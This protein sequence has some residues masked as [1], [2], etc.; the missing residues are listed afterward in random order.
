MAERL[1]VNTGPLIA[2]HRA[3]ALD[4]VGR[5]PIE[6][7]SPF[8][9][10]LPWE[11][12]KRSLNVGREIL[13]DDQ[14][15]SWFL[16]PDIEDLDADADPATPRFDTN[17]E[18]LLVNYVDTWR[19]RPEAV[20]RIPNFFLASDYVRTYTDLATMEAA[21]EAARRAV[22]G[23][24]RAAHADVAPCEIWNLHEPELLVPLRAYD[25]VRY[26]QGLPWDGAA[27]SLAR[28]LLSL[29]T[30]VSRLSGGSG[31]GGPLGHLL[32]GL[33]QIPPD[34]AGALRAG[35][36]AAPTER[37]LA[38]TPDK[39]LGAGDIC[40]RQRRRRRGR[41]GRSHIQRRGTPPPEDPGRLVSAGPVVAAILPAAAG[42]PETFE[43]QLASYRDRVKPLVLQSIP[44]REPKKHLYDLI[45]GQLSRDGKGIRP[46][47]CLATCGAFGGPV[48][49]ALPSA[50]A[51]E[52]LHNALL[53]HDDIEDSSDYRRDGP[54]LH[55]Q[56][57]IPLAVNAGDALNAM[58]VRVLKQN[59]SLLGP[60]LS[61]RIFDEFDHLS[62]ETIEG[63]AMELGWI[64]DNDCT[65]TEEDYLLMV[66]KKTGWY[67]FIHPAR[68]GALI[69]QPE[70]ANLDAFNRFGYY[71]GAAFQI[72]DDVLNLAGDR[73]K[74]GKE[75]G[76]DLLEGKRTLI[77]SHVLRSSNALERE[78]LRSFLA[79]PRA[80]R[81][82]REV[83][84]IY[85]LLHRYG[86]LDYARSSARAFADGAQ[87][88][89]DTAYADASPGPH[90][91]F[92]R[93]LLD[94]MVTRD[95]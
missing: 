24:I 11:Q 18:P 54:T 30:G 89:F 85:D 73:R 84:W 25:R 27:M 53:V 5:L 95:A 41:F 38:G 69:A 8:E 42:A 36:R 83:A 46:A 58:S 63:Q 3:G 70:T 34:V 78:R 76:G 48:E 66:L 79:K 87:R 31:A 39:C 22:N 60:A 82:P 32:Q 47:L 37:R 43:A 26:R 52:L 17:A 65:T 23:V 21:N 10:R 67:S 28:S 93:S 68:I 1:V 13:R 77:L 56:Y 15:H 49:N 19:L 2:L 59:L 74:Y 20:T 4:V 16:D 75:I 44:D 57:G 50:A 9:V 80:Q 40:R 88:E 62:I 35:P 55:R 90:L 92:L 33:R 94:Y 29:T 7:L 61:G 45:A 86:S 72:R 12:L 14:L 91:D 71:L 81:L 6:F 64:R 51:L